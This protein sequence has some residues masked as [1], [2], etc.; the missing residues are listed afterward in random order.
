MSKL[1]TVILQMSKQ[2]PLQRYCY[3]RQVC[4]SF[5][6][7]S[8]PLLGRGKTVSAGKRPGFGIAQ[9]GEVRIFLALFSLLPNYDTAPGRIRRSRR[10]SVHGTGAACHGSCKVRIAGPPEWTVAHQP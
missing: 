9:P 4:Q 8:I 5:L 6:P 7:R 1:G 10:D 2:K 3:A